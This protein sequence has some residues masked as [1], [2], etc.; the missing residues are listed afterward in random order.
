MCLVCTVSRALTSRYTWKTVTTIKVVSVS[1]NPKSFL[2]SFYHPSLLPLFPRQPVI[3]FLSLKIRL[4]LLQFSVNGIFRHVFFVACVLSL[5][6]LL[7][8][9]HVAACI[10]SSHLLVVQQYVFHWTERLPFFIHLPAGPWVVS[11]SCC[12]K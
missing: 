5:S 9:F 12:F 1:I 3:Y 2:S 4:Q 6:T 10:S 8:L 7:R 11:G